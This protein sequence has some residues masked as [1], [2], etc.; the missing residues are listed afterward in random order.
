MKYRILSYLSLLILSIIGVSFSHNPFGR[1]PFYI[2]L[3]ATLFSVIYA[4]AVWEGF[5]F[6]ENKSG[7]IYTRGMTFHYRFSLSNDS[8][9]YFTHIRA[10]FCSGGENIRRD[11]SVMPHRTECFET[12]F[13]FRHIGKYRI[14]LVSAKVYGL[15]DLFGIPY[16]N[17]CD[18]VLVE[19]RIE[20][21]DRLLN[22]CADDDNSRQAF[23]SFF[24][25]SLTGNYDGV[26]DYIPGDSLKNIHWKLSA[27]TGKYMS[28]IHER[29]DSFTI[30][31]YVD[32][33]HPV[34]DGEA[35]LCI[36]DSLVESV[37]S[38]AGYSVEHSCVS[39]LIYERNGCIEH[40]DIA[41][42][43]ALKKAARD[44]ASYSFEATC[45]IEDLLGS[46][47]G[48][49]PVSQNIVVFTPNLSY[50]IAYSAAQMKGS[51]KNPM[52]FYIVEPEQNLTDE[53]K[54]LDFLENRGVPVQLVRV[55]Q[56]GL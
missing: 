26:R 28:R 1:M 22:I 39:E 30:G 7:K 3:Y 11:F 14:G 24:N 38:V 15:W 23:L 12:E 21:M 27:H 44:F 56:P 20:R 9:F 29:T 47:Q 53:L 10:V 37:F 8:P 45:R 36:F 17:L 35:A 16:K 34:F 46:I 18:S 40:F 31:L 42:A 6:T 25:N 41:N 43:A 48:K 55:P 50:D 2:I 33:F 51:G 19:P 52:L 54:M 4:L 49:V 5:S 13:N 32:L